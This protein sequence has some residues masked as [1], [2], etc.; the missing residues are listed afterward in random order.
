MSREHN[1]GVENEADPSSLK[2][3]NEWLLLFPAEEQSI[4]ITQP[5]NTQLNYTHSVAT[6][7]GPGL[8]RCSKM[9]TEMA[10]VS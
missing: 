10:H 2:L 9:M 1:T 3:F 7:P 4:S 6:I 5:R 8:Y